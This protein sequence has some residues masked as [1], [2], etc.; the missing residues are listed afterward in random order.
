M[1]PN[2][3]Q[4]AFRKSAEDI[5]PRPSKRPESLTFHIGLV[6]AQ[7]EV[8]PYVSKALFES[9]AQRYASGKRLLSETHE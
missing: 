3:G 9:S 1:S 2:I 6:F 8:A 5:A 4:S 7:Y